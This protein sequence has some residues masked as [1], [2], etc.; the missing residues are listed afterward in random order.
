MT[1]SAQQRKVW[2]IASGVIVLVLALGYAALNAFKLDF[3]SRRRPNRLSC[4]PGFR[5]SRSWCL[6][7]YW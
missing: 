5:R 3:L 4:S 7:A 2:S 1:A 6:W